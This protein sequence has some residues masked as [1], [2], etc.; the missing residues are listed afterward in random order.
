MTKTVF[1]AFLLFINFSILDA[2]HCGVSKIGIGNIFG[3]NKVVR[4]QFPW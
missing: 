1:L 2:Q 3:G 4:G